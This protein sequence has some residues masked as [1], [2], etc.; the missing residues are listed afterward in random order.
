MEKNVINLEKDGNLLISINDKFTTKDGNIYP[1]YIINGSIL[2]LSRQKSKPYKFLYSLIREITIY[3]L[4]INKLVLQIKEY[5]KENKEINYKIL[6][7][8][9]IVYAEIKRLSYNLNFNFKYSNSYI[10][11]CELDGISR[12]SIVSK[13]LK[14]VDYFNETIK[15]D[16]S[17]ILNINGLEFKDA[18]SNY[19]TG[20]REGT[21]FNVDSRFNRENKYKKG[22][23]NN[24]K[25]VLIISTV[26]ENSSDYIELDIYNIF[27][28]IIKGRDSLGED[29]ANKSLYIDTKLETMPSTSLNLAPIKGTDT[30]MQQLRNKR[31]ILHYFNGL[32]LEFHKKYNYEVYNID[33]NK[34]DITFKLTCNKCGKKSE[35][36]NSNSFKKDYNLYIG[37]GSNCCNFE[38]TNTSPYSLD[39]LTKCVKYKHYYFERI[40]KELL[41]CPICKIEDSYVFFKLLKRITHKYIIKAIP[42][43]VDKGFYN[44]I[45]NLCVYIYNNNNHVIGKIV[46]QDLYGY[47]QVE[48][49]KN[50][51][52][53]RYI[54][55][56]ILNNEKACL[57]ILESMVNEMHIRYV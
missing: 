27:K 40:N 52:V 43:D 47:R 5:K 32:P 24:N 44:S 18:I 6:L 10:E 50:N 20:A 34:N 33:Y 57:E 14:D 15:S 42:R 8:Q 21:T 51:I 48:S 3:E 9:K 11:Q 1:R 31:S 26:D 36:L 35:K 41:A 49:I 17:S 13:I 53:F 2:K 30:E 19:I 37:S 39:N 38:G 25:E 45:D 46:F 16:Y 12:N 4:D 29:Y 54:P 7:G 28:Y 22:L 56:S 23:L 55:K